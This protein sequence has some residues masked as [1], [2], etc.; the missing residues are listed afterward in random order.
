MASTCQR[1]E[2]RLHVIPIGWPGGACGSGRSALVCASLGGD[3]HKAAWVD[4]G[5]GVVVGVDHPVHP[6]EN[7]IGDDRAKRGRGST[8]ALHLTDWGVG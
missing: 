6:P 5:H 4:P 2:S 1:P 3:R 7:V 8:R